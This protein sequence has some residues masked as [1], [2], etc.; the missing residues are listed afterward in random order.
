ML[1]RTR[2]VLYS[3]YVDSLNITAWLPP[4]S[5]RSWVCTWVLIDPPPCTGT[6]IVD[7]TVLPPSSRECDQGEPDQAVDEIA[8]ALHRE[9]CGVAVRCDRYAVSGGTTG[10][11][12]AGSMSTSPGA[13]ATATINTWSR[14]DVARPA[15]DR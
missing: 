14:C 9:V 11:S 4:S 5:S 13:T 8:Q 1:N 10:P 2:P 7:V 6:V 12:C 3:R 15:C